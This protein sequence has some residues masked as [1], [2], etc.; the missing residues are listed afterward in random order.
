MSSADTAIMITPETT[1]TPGGAVTASSMPPMP[2]PSMYPALSERPER[3]FARAS[4]S[5]AT[6][7]G[8]AP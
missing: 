2:G 1:K 6:R 3:L 7:F 4:S 8:T 5:S